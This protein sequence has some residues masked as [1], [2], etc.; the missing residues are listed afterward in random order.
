MTSLEIP[1]IERPQLGP[2]FGLETASLYDRILQRGQITAIAGLSGIGKSLMVQNVAVHAIHQGGAVLWINC[3]MGIEKVHRR[4]RTILTDSP[5][6][7]F[8][9]PQLDADARKALATLQSSGRFRVHSYDSAQHS[10]EA[11]IAEWSN[12]EDQR[13]TTVIIDGF[14]RVQ[15]GLQPQ[16]F[17]ALCTRLAN[18]AAA[19]NICIVVTSQVNRDGYKHEVV[20]ATDLASSMD[21]ANSAST[22]VMLGRRVADKLLTASVV[23]DRNG[24]F[25]DRQVFRL[26]VD[27]SL[28]LTV[29]RVE[30][31]IRVDERTQ[32][33]ASAIACVNCEEGDIYPPDPDDQDNENAPADHRGV[34]LYHGSKGY[35]AIGR[36][37]FDAAMFQERQWGDLG[38]LLGLYEMAAIGPQN[39]YAPATRMQVAIGRG[40]VMVSHQILAD[41]WGLEKKQVR[42]FLERAERE[43]LI[44]VQHIGQNGELEPSM[45][46]SK[47]TTIRKI[48][49]VL[50]LCHYDRNDGSTNPDD[51]QKGTSKGAS[52]GTTMAQP[53]RN[54]GATQAQPGPTTEE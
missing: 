43:G 17:A 22:V 4:M 41:R 53:G 37:V 49:S 45:G 32:T 30:D 38:L 29:M 14:D 25:R 18:L 3:D 46:T 7:E 2:A 54:V 26:Q 44:Q 34:K 5:M 39:L 51:V 8:S 47:G 1:I 48:G 42:R 27:P 13:A 11:V 33:S 40:Q 31:S 24:L 16:D 15:T 20:A 19:R 21:K 9:E 36:Q 52:M 35:I 6:D 10:L 23:K 12:K 50:T 28:R